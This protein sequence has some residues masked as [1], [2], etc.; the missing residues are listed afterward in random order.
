[1]LNGELVRMFNLA[2]NEQM[3][4][5]EPLTEADKGRIREFRDRITKSFLESKHR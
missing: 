5:M 2:I 1:M 4:R 3:R